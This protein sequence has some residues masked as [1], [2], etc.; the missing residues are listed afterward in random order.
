M[1]NDKEFAKNNDMTKYLTI[2]EREN[3]LD[4]HRRERD[5]RIRDRI[6]TVL[7]YDDGY[8]YTEIARI[9][10]LDDETIRRHIKDYFKHKKL[11]PENGGSDSKL[12]E[13][14]SQQ[15]IMHLREKTYLYVKDICAY[16][17]QIYQKTYSLSGMTKWLHHQGFRYKK[18][19]GV[20]AKAN[21][22]T[23]QEFIKR[24]ERLKKK[25]GGNEPI[26]FADSV[27][28][29]HQTRLSYGWILKGERKEIATTGRQKRLNFMGGICLD[30]HRVIYEQADQVNAESIKLFLAKLRRLHPEKNKIHLLLDNAGY[31]R[32]KEVKSFAKRIRIQLHYLPPYSPNLNPIERL[33][34]ILHEQVTYNKYYEKFSDF[35]EATLVFFKTIGRKKS[36]LR[37]RITDNFQ[38]LH[39]PLF[40]S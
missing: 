5:G 32:S 14:E 27:H 9:L 24:Y 1:H 12:S 33:W 16:V 6:K 21:Q 28:P 26:Y 17:K 8:S 15:L 18:P 19:H 7:A 37:K 39:S 13:S 34:K 36:I 40:A 3:L 31:H 20:P 10:L 29:Q 11:Q 25:A 23:Q 4:A 30:G 22:A 35:S 38:I 2:K